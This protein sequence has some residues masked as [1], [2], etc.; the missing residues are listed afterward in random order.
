MIV[1]CLLIAITMLLPVSDVGAQ[2]ADYQFVSVVTMSGPCCTDEGH[3][4]AVDNDGNVLIAGRRGSIDLN[5]DGEIDLPTQGS[6]DTLISKVSM[7][8]NANTG[9]TTGPGGP[10]LDRADGITS[11]RHGGVYAVGMFNEIL[12]SHRRTPDAML[13]SAGGS[14]G[15]LLRYDQDGRPL[16]GREIGGLGEDRMWDVASD[17][18]GNAILIGTV[19]GPV[20]VD[21]DGN[22]DVNA[23]QDGQALVA[24][25]SPGGEFRWMRASGGDASASGLTIATGPNDEVYIAG[26]YRNGAP[27]FDGDGEPDLPVSEK[28]SAD[29]M[30]LKD[31]VKL[32]YNAFYARLDDDGSPLWVNGVSGPALQSVASL[33]IAANGDLLVLGGYSASPDF[34]GDEVADLEFRSMSDRM[35]RYHGDTNSFLLR[36]TPDGE[37]VWL[38]RYT[39]SASHVAAA[40]SHIVMSGSYSNALDIDDDGIP[41]RESDGDDQL[42]GFAAILDDEG[43]L[44]QVITVVGDYVDVVNAAGF[45]PDGNTLYLTGRTSIG[46]DFD[47]DGEIEAASVCHKAGEVYLATFA[48]AD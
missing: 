26:W 30:A 3:D 13:H 25:F 35:Y 38:R 34:D 29:V 9:W 5:Y 31:P 14:D 18:D 17:R 39:A 12:Q 40:G 8:E 15:F 33:T 47:G 10:Q 44:Q 21:R 41:E 19:V 45:S 6:P 43:Q 48:I 16:W 7:I 28:S 2:S 4:L 11:D 1:S 22:T 36:V 37:Q 27:D 23:G 20:D 24:S 32:E 42:E 46:A